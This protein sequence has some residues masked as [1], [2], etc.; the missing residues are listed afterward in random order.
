GGF[1]AA[2][3]FCQAEADAAGVTGTFHALLAGSSANAASRFDTNG[4]TWVR[5]DGVPLATTATDVMAGNVRAP[6]DVTLAGTYTAPEIWTGATLQPPNGATTNMYTCAD[7]TDSVGTQQ[8]ADTI[9]MF[10][11][12]YFFGA[13]G[14]I[15]CTQPLRHLYCLQQ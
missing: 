5:A 1:A 9:A 7:W 12:T 4:P 6:L 15:T 8:G 13:S 11:G 3:A 14:A 10:S 2:D